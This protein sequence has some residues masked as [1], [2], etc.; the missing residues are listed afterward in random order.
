[1]V[2]N[3]RPQMRTASMPPGMTT[4][5]AQP[6][7]P[8]GVVGSSTSSVA[9]SPPPP[10]YERRIEEALLRAPSRINQPHLHPDKINGALW[11]GV[12]PEVHE[13]IKAIWQ[14][15]YWGPWKSWSGE[16]RRGTIYGL[17]NLQYKNK[18]PSESVPTV[19][20]R[21]IDI[22]MRVSGLEGLTQEIKSDVHALKTDFNEGTAR[23]QST[24]NMILQLLQPQASNSQPSQSQHHY[25]SHS[26]AQPEGHGQAPSPPH[27]Q[28]QAPG[29][30]QP[31]LITDNHSVLDRWCNA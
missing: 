14:G 30:A 1:M 28:P 10:T 8:P 22:E 4:T 9:P 31:H 26:E 18:R 20:K 13:L 16:T 19:L 21:D 24:L 3:V 6:T 29:D 27:D 11:I 15:N 23:T 12:D 2:R 5:S 7:R 25:P 17:G